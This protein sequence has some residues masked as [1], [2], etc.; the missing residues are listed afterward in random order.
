MS[1]EQV[2]EALERYNAAEVEYL[3]TGN[4]EPVRRVFAPDAVVYQAD[5]LPY[6]GEHRGYA[7]LERTLATVRETWSEIEALE[8]NSV[9]DGDTAAV[10]ERV[11]FVSRKTGRELVTEVFAR[12]KVQDGLIVE[13]R[14]FYKDTAAVLATITP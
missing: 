2:Q 6:G 3:A 14:P 4:F 11:R 7:E 5:A 10:W 13:G 1:V 9:E 12:I 8:V